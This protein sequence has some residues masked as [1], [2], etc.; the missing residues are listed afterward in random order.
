MA[1][2][3]KQMNAKLSGNI[4]SFPVK[5]ATAIFRGTA[6]AIDSAGYLVQID[7]DAKMKFVGIAE[8]SCTVAQAV[9][10]GTV[11]IRVRRHGI[12]RMTK[13]TTSAVTD[14]GKLVY[15]HTEHTAA[16][17][18]LVG[19]AAACPTSTNIIGLVV[20]REPDSPGAATYDKNYLMVDITPAPWSAADITTHAALADQ[21]AHSTA[22]IS[23]IITTET[24]TNPTTTAAEFYGGLIS[25]TYAGVTTVV[26]PASGIVA[27]TQ[28]RIVKAHATAGALLISATTLVGAQCTGN[29]FIGCAN[30]GDSVV[31][32]NVGADSYR[33]VEVNQ[34]TVLRA[35]AADDTL[36]Q[37]E[38][39]GGAVSL[40]KG[41]AQ[42]VSLPASGVP[43][44]AKCTLIN[45][46][47]AH[48]RTISATALVGGAASSNAHATCDAVGDN[49][50]V[51]CNGDDDYTVIAEVVA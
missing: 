33:V 26:L 48:A 32:Q 40:T 8:E 15:A 47:S 31:I 6:V 27:G 37:A 23:P 24:L 9:A 51:I 42:A 43:V 7:N 20:R 19:L 22:A 10:D 2:G 12:I 30:N 28:C 38:Y 44:N 36:T 21:T 49:I 34:Q 18:G 35:E 17:D 46:G 1:G 4:L 45:N 14:V 13:N 5:I 25:C 50:T 29:A 39:L 3:N 11:A 41:S 16:A